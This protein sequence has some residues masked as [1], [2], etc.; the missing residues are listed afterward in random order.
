[1]ATR[2]PTT[3]KKRVAALPRAVGSA[4]S[5]DARHALAAIETMNPL[6]GLTA[7]GAQNLFDAARQGDTTRLQWL[8]NE[9][10]AAIPAMLVCAER[11]AAAVA[12]YDWH[13]A[14]RDHIRRGD[15][16]L[17]AEQVAAL[18][19]AFAT[20]E[21]AN[22][23][24]VVEHLGAAFFRGYAHASPHWTADGLGV[25]GF[26]LLDG[27]NVVRDAV[28]EP[29]VWRW[30]PN[31]LAT[32]AFAGLPE[33]PP[34]ELLS[35]VRPRHIDYPALQICLR[36]ALG[37]KAWG[38]F[39]D[40]YGI[41]PVIVIMP[42]DV[43][44]NRVG[45]YVTA[46]E[47]VTDGGSGALPYGSLVHYAEGGRGVDPFTA[48]VERQEKS[49]VLLGTGGMLTSLVEA[50]GIG[51]GAT[52]A[53]SDTWREI[54][55]RDIRFVGKAVDRQI[56]EPIMERAFP[57]RP[58]LAYFDFDQDPAPT[59]DQLF[60]T[61]AKARQ[62]GY[63][64][65]QS[66]LEEKSG[67]KLEKI[68]AEPFP[69]AP[70][71]GWAVQNSEAGPGNARRNEGNTRENAPE[72]SGAGREPQEPPRPSDAISGALASA[73]A[74]DNQA[75]A[76]FIETSESAEAAQ[77]LIKKYLAARQADKAALVETAMAQAASEGA[78]R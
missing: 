55:R 52:S 2:A 44:P 33:I 78:S 67:Y 8:Y 28:R 9:I 13:V 35:L 59:A 30:N 72:P 4:L 27:W 14:A 32:T 50:T 31:A 51:G 16:N 73:I 45:E 29:G 64:V 76:K 26:D 53:H 70:G 49:I 6:R 3:R 60:E 11:R 43:D 69:A 66:E 12:G 36:V 24:D 42:P 38:K 54:V 46:A 61:A 1:M 19:E 10:E 25:T 20:V 57:G 21:Q 23:S 37:D 5:A 41:P 65:V 77:E 56:A 34:E 68:A 22:F 75:I 63:L 74:A 47:R 17:Q 48:F 39:I 15:E 62:A 71:G 7:T 18:E 40:R 58:R